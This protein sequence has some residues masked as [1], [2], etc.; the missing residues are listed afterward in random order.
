MTQADGGCQRV[1]SDFR[2]GPIP[3]SHRANIFCANINYLNIDAKRRHAAARNFKQPLAGRK[4]NMVFDK[5]R[6]FRLWGVLKLTIIGLG[7]LLAAFRFPIY[8]DLF[9]PDITWGIPLSAF[10]ILCIAV[11]IFKKVTS[12][13]GESEKNS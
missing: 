2:V 12:K 5:K 4:I 7:L 9:G 11:V 8:P 13:P 10:F 6:M 1:L 3:F